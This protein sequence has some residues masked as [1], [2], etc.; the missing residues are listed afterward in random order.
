MNWELIDETIRIAKIRTHEG[1]VIGRDEKLV[2]FAL[3]R[4]CAR[5]SLAEIADCVLMSECRVREVLD[6]LERGQIIR[7]RTRA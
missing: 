1:V 5:F 4:P 7:R 6:G 3:A 2:L